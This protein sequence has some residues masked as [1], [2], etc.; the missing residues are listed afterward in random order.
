MERSSQERL[1]LRRHHQAEPPNNH[2]TF[3]YVERDS[4]EPHRL[5]QRE[6]LNES[7][8]FNPQAEDTFYRQYLIKN[9]NSLEQLPSARRDNRFGYKTTSNPM[10]L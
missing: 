9:E 3:R 2:E 4:G 8:H 5:Q 6:I 10:R 1:A 7:S